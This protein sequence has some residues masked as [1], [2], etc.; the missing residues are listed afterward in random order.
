M[1][2]VINLN[3][4]GSAERGQRT[5]KKVNELSSSAPQ[6]CPL[7]KLAAGRLHCRNQALFCFADGAVITGVKLTSGLLPCKSTGVL[8]ACWGTEKRSFVR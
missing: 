5:V 7:N 3:L 4:G 1:N 6:I 8:T 2:K